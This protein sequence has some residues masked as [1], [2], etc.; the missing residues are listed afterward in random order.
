M[1]IQT[2]YLKGLLFLKD[3]VDSYRSNKEVQQLVLDTFFNGT[4]TDTQFRT[5]NFMQSD[6]YADAC[7]KY[8]VSLIYR[9]YEKFGANSFSIRVDVTNARDILLPP[10]IDTQL[11]TD[12]DDADIC[13]K[14]LVIPIYY[15]NSE[16]NTY[17]L[18]CLKTIRSIVGKGTCTLESLAIDVC[19]LFEPIFF[20]PTEDKT[21]GFMYINASD[22][23]STQKLVVGLFTNTEV[24][25]II[26]IGTKIYIEFVKDGVLY[27]H[28]II[29]VNSD[30]GKMELYRAIQFANALD[31]PTTLLTNY[32]KNRRDILLCQEIK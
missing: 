29:N 30:S 19:S 26:K 9:V 27:K 20:F 12:S 25:R 16:S 18:K 4:Y 28:S 24:F 10:Y 17:T 14:E 6:S 7:L 32:Q 2:M 3:L 31:R 5:L 15:N 1:N 11:H 21:K 13:F 23:T 22:I 8:V